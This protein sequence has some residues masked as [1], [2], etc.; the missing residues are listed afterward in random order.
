MILNKK[1]ISTYEQQLFQAELEKYRP[2]QQRLLTAVHKQSQYMKELT[3]T[4]NNL[5]QD[6]RVR[7]EQSKYENIKRQRSAVTTRYKKLH[8]EFLDLEDGLLG[9]KQWYNEMK[10]TVDSL[11]KN[12]ETFV[13]NRRS[14]GAHL[15][16]QIEQERAGAANSQA[17]RERERLRG[18]MERMSMDP[19]SNQM[20]GRTQSLS[21]G[22]SNSTSSARYPAT[23]ISGQYQVPS[24]PPPQGTFPP[25]ARPDRSWQTQSPRNDPYASQQ[26]QHQHHN[27][28][29][30]L[31]NPGT[32]NQSQPGSAPPTQTQFPQNIQ[33]PYGRMPQ[34]QQQYAAAH[35]DLPGPPPGPP[36]LG[37]QQSFPGQ[38]LVGNAYGS[39][40]NGNSN[41]GQQQGAG[42]DPYAGLNAWK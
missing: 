26:N 16:N 9:A 12:V 38:H 33:Q 1:S 39:A 19:A 6:K 41:G 24:S 30:G 14:E 11:E 32:Y 27:Q 7:S 15:L 2:H 29:Q 42:L 8:Q 34:Q 13:S 5:L 36:P 31:Y 4:F 28:H 21:H 18:L 37:P 10:D 40:A 23:N 17:D 35:Y 22:P 3:A 20:P 25:Q